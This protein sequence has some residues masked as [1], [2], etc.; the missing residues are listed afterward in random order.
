MPTT[1]PCSPPFPTFAV[2]EDLDD[3]NYL[4]SLVVD[5]A[6]TNAVTI[7][8]KYER[9]ARLAGVWFNPV[10]GTVNTFDDE[11][12]DGYELFLRGSWF[13]ERLTVRT[14]AFYTD[15]VDQQVFVGFSG[16]IDDAQFVN[17]P[18]SHNEGLEI[19]TMWTQGAWKWWLSGGLLHAEVDELEFFDVNA[20][21]NDFPYAPDWTLAGGLLF[22]G[23]QGLFVELDAMLRPE[24]NATL[25]NVPGA[26]SERRFAA[27]R[28]CRVGV[29]AIRSVALR[30]QRARR[31]V[32]RLLRPRRGIRWS[33]AEVRRR[34]SA[35]NRAHGVC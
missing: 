8:A 25:D 20:S 29:R 19:E 33:A 22:G 34:R 17:A 23:T 3:Y 11:I 13:D 7:G 32:S 16:N 24:A 10:R 9:T 27:Q 31:S 2:T 28:T 18:H 35:R 6:L 21:G 12:A 5:Y 26:V 14:N 30:T 4:P 15:L 1:I